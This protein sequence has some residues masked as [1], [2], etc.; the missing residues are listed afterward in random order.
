RNVLL[1][2]AFRQ[3]V[4]RDGHHPLAWSSNFTS[5]AWHKALLDGY[6]VLHGLTFVFCKVFGSEEALSTLFT[7]ETIV[8][9]MPSL[10]L[11]KVWPTREA[12]A[13]D[14][15]GVGFDTTVGNNVCLQ[16]IWT[17]EFFQAAWGKERENT[18]S[19]WTAILFHSLVNGHVALQLVLA[20]EGGLA[21]LAGKRRL[22]S[23]NE[24]VRFEVVLR[25]ELL[26]AFLTLKLT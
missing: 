22:A 24:H 10:M 4:W 18:G 23:V 25:F 26:A 14:V 7:L 3:G 2:S 16:F 19:E 20:V 12:L 5:M 15:A 9:V 1:A 11:N 6:T 13:A 21:E 17:I 8:Q